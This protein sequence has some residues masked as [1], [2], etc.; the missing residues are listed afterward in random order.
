MADDS[1]Y[2]LRLTFAWRGTQISLVGGERVAMIVPA[3][4][5]EPQDADTTGYSFALLD[6]N[7]N[8][9]YRRP[10]HRPL[11]IDSEA[12]APGRGRSIERVPLAASEG[13][14]TVLVPDLTDAR[15][16]RLSG[17]ADP[18]RPADRSTELIRLDVDA[19]RKASVSRNP[20]GT[21]PRHG[22]KG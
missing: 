4:A 21:P 5:P 9:V 2:A 20:A 17:P 7:G 6:S 13:Q 12:Y 3:S 16:F 22:S 14:F 11:R 18:T 1:S 10:L 8:V 19:L 15:T